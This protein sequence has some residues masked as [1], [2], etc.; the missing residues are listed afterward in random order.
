MEAFYLFYLN[1]E[2][3]TNTSSRSTKLEFY[4]K[5]RGNKENVKASQLPEA[6]SVSQ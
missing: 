2:L 4:K 6:T 5:K 3:P 1:E